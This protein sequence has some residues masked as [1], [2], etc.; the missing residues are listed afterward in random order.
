SIFRKVE[1]TGLV[2]QLGDVVSVDIGYVT[3]D[4]DFFHL[5]MEGLRRWGIP[6]E[7]SVRTLRSGRKLQG[8]VFTDADWDA[9]RRN[10]AHCY[11]LRLPPAVPGRKLKNLRPYLGEG[12][13]RG[14]DRR[15]QCRTRDPWF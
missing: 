10:M 2:R 3:G 6:R 11:L 14:I 7:Y 1:T 8:C 15:Y 5:S 4:H 12:I 9:L 13:R